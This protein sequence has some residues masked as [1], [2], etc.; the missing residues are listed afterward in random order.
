MDTVT[1]PA[2]S[3]EELL[4]KFVLVK[5]DHDAAPELVKQYGVQ[6][7]P[8]LRVLA[9]DGKQL[10]KLVGFSSATKLAARLQAA[11]ARLAGHAPEERSATDAR[12]CATRPPTQPRCRGCRGVARTSYLRNAWRNGWKAPPFRARRARCAAWASRSAPDRR[13]PRRC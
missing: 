2:K 1:Y 8:D 12:S 7:L 13:T 10:D 5:V 9:P 4:A 6:P 3:L 11:L